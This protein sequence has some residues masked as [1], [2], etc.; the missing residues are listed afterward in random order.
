MRSMLILLAPLVDVEVSANGA[1]SAAARYSASAL[2]RLPDQGRYVRVI[3][4]VGAGLVA[5]ARLAVSAMSINS[6][7]R[8]QL[9]CPG[10]QEAP[11]RSTG[12]APGPSG[13]GPYRTPPGTLVH[14]RSSS[15]TPNPPRS[16]N[17]VQGSNTHTRGLSDV[18]HQEPLHAPLG[19]YS[20]GGLQDPAPVP[21]GVSPLGTQ[22]PEYRQALVYVSGLGV[23]LESAL[24]RAS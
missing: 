1:H 3:R 18:A 6:P 21:N 8:L 14:A 15:G 4:L 19:H 7:L 23:A 10:V 24:L 12:S 2:T 13:G 17:A 9:V 11:I 22:L 5:G 20:L 16:P